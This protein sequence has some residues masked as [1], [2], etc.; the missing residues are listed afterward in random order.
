MRRASNQAFREAAL[1]R[2]PGRQGLASE[3]DRNQLVEAFLLVRAPLNNPRLQL[4][5][6]QTKES[7]NGSKRCN[8]S[9]SVK[10]GTP[11]FKMEASEAGK[12]R[13]YHA[14]EFVFPCLWWLFFETQIKTKRITSNYSK[15]KRWPD[16]F[17]HFMVQKGDFSQL[18]GN[19]W[20]NCISK[21]DAP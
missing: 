1:P 17:C 9:S 7:E 4:F 18:L 6:L 15:K 5:H 21:S 16:F 20:K 2:P 14:T 12:Q 10:W 19:R 13:L 11:A 8:I 3:T